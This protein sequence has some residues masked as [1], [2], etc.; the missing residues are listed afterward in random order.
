MALPPG[1]VPKRV[2][3]L[4]NGFH[5]TLSAFD[6]EG[7]FEFPVV[8]PGTYHV[9]ATAWDRESDRWFTYARMQGRIHPIQ[10]ASN[11]RGV[12]QA[13]EKPPEYLQEF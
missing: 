8:P 7:G 1:V 12:H 9:S 6:E 11:G 3:A 10:R 5:F 13:V 2:D 4:A